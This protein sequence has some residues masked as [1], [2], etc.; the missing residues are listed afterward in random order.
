ME[1]ARIFIMQL[2]KG[3]SIG[4]QVP[5]IDEFKKILSGGQAILGLYSTG[6]TY[7]TFSAI[8]AEIAS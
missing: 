1:E 3:L 2:Y 7:C 5:K 8:M 6:F 4:H